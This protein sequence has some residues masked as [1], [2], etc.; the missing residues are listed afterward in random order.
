VSRCETGFVRDPVVPQLP[1]PPKFATQERRSSRQ[2][3]GDCRIQRDTDKRRRSQPSPRLA[4]GRLCASEHPRRGSRPFP[5]WAEEARAWGRSSS[6]CPNR[7][8]RG[9]RRHP[10]DAPGDW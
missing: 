10:L 8:V 1:A 5:H 9:S 4:S 3:C 7:L 6:S 2:G